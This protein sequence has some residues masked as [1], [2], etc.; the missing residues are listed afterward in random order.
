MTC[1]LVHISSAALYIAML[2]SLDQYHHSFKVVG[3]LLFDPKKTKLYNCPVIYT[4][5]TLII[6]ASVLHQNHMKVEC[7]V[8]I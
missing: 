4:V 7:Q 1:S 5:Q 8:Y 3:D 6:P 2:F